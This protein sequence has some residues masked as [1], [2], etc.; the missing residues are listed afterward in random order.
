MDFELAFDYN[1][2][3]D[4]KIKHWGL[5]CWEYVNEILKQY[6][7]HQSK[8]VVSSWRELPVVLS[9]DEIEA[10]NKEA[11][12]KLLAGVENIYQQWLINPNIEILVPQAYYNALDKEG[13]IQVT[14]EEKKAFYNEAKL[15]HMNDIRFNSSGKDVSNRIK[16]II[17]NTIGES[18][19]IIIKNIAKGLTLISY[20]SKR[21][22]KEY[23]K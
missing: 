4:D 19:S 12:E 23:Q 10:K 7:K 3:L 21:R 15:I 20:F 6:K 14:K 11:H 17:S 18:D 16:Q 9:E 13:L 2:T 8:L 22:D 5:F 1:D